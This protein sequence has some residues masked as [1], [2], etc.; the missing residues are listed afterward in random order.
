M[1]GDLNALV[2]W[3]CPCCKL[4]VSDAVPEELAFA[5]SISAVVP[6]ESFARDGDAVERG[7]GG[8]GPAEGWSPNS[9]VPSHPLLGMGGLM[10]ADMWTG[11]ESWQR[12]GNADVAHR[13]VPR[14]SG[15]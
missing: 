12:L 7:M 4:E 2:R 1:S 11:F 14:S 9:L 15:S 10:C 8:E 5:P 6:A 13:D 3:R